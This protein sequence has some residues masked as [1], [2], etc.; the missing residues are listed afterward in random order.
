MSAIYTKLWFLTLGR[1]WSDVQWITN[2]GVT[3]ITLRNDDPI[4]KNLKY[5]MMMEVMGYDP[6]KYCIVTNVMPCFESKLMLLM[7]YLPKKKMCF[8]PPMFVLREPFLRDPWR[9]WG[10]MFTCCRINFVNP[11]IQTLFHTQQFVTFLL[12]GYYKP[13]FWT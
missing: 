13:T 12:T 10:Q 9:E 7:A 5:A 11:L 4:L 1:S 6:Y 2:W 3:Y 8:Y